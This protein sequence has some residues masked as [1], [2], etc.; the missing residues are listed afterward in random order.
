VGLPGLPHVRLARASLLDDLH[1][2][3]LER[4]DDAS[5]LVAMHRQRRMW[6]NDRLP[7]LHVVIF[8]LHDALCSSRAL[9]RTHDADTEKKTH[10]KRKTNPSLHFTLRTFTDWNSTGRMKSIRLL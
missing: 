9:L 4:D 8:K 6:N 5:V 10:N 1:R 7:H 2:A 3:A